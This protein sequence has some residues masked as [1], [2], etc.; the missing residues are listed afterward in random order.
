MN[1]PKKF[2]S[3]MLLMG[4]VATLPMLVSQAH[5]D[6]TPVYS[7]ITSSE[8]TLIELPQT[9]QVRLLSLT[10]DAANVPS[11]YSS[12]AILCSNPMPATM[13][14]VVTGVNPGDSVFVVASSDKN[15]SGHTALNPRATIGASNLAIVG[16]SKLDNVSV[17]SGTR[18]AITVPVDLGAIPTLTAASSFYMQA[19]VIPENA[20]SPSSWR[21]S[22]LDEIRKGVSATNSYGQVTSYCN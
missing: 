16:A 21:F 11:S 18:A 6:V 8:I 5:A 15:F 19:L 4:K 17:A 1:K 22:E 20:A 13:S 2:S 3:S 12:A 14:V 7:D 9:N 10:A